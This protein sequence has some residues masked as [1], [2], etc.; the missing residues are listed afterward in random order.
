MGKELYKWIRN[1]NELLWS[2]KTLLVTIIGLL[3]YQWLFMLT[4]NYPIGHILT[5]QV[6]G[7][8]IIWA[9]HVRGLAL[10]MVSVMINKRLKAF[11]SDTNDDIDRHIK[12]VHKKKCKKC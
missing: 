1:M 7:L 3:S 5:L 8:L 4:M 10:G 2:P 6:V 11:L 12:T 9:V